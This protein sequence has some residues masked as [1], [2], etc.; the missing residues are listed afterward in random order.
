[1]ADIPEDCREAVL[2][3]SPLPERYYMRHWYDNNF[4]FWSYAIS[5]LLALGIGTS[6]L[7]HLPLGPPNSK[8]GA[9]VLF[10]FTCWLWPIWLI[11]LLGYY[12]GSLLF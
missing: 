3:G 7:V 11:I 12:L 10:I 5:C 8:F 1:M 4:V 2:T 6:A 9:A